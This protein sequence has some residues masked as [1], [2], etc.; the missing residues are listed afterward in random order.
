MNK[1]LLQ[2][3]LGLT[4]IVLLLAGCKGASAKP[5]TCDV[6][7]S[8]NKIVVEINL[9]AEETAFIDRHDLTP[10]G[11]S[12]TP[13]EITIESGGSSV[14]YSKTGN[15]YTI[16]YTVNYKDGEIKSYDI[17]IKGNVYGDVEHTCT[18]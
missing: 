9:P 6:Y 4:M 10:Q 16:A 8:G 11:L 14:D 17:S 15:T 13:S 3:V 12:G 5:P 2:K 1:G 18:K 7:V